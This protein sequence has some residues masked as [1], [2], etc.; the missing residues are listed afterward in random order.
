MDVSPCRLLGEIRYPDEYS[1]ERVG[2]IETELGEVLEDALDGLAVS[3]LE[4]APG[5]ES[6]GFEAWCEGCSSEEAWEICEALLPLVDDG[7]VSRLVVVRGLEET[8]S[9]YYFQGETI[10]EVTLERP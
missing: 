8:I 10:D 1:Y 9:V 5:P 4:V 7:P 2:E 3:R 6:Y